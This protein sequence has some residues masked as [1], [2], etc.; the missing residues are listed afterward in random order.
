MTQISIAPCN[1]P[2]AEI[3]N[4][5]LSQ[6]LSEE[7]FSTIRQAF[8]DHGL[9]FFRDQNITPEQ[10]IAFAKRWG[11]INI[12]RF[13]T[14]VDGYPE[15]AEVRKEPNQTTNIGGGW[16][17][18][19]S[20]DAE[21]ATGSILVAR[22]LPPQGGDTMFAD[23]AAA[24][25]ALDDETKDKLDGLEAIHS[26][27]HIFGGEAAYRSESDAG[28]RLQNANAAD[29]LDDVVHPVV[30]THPLSGRKI[31]YVNAA[32]TVG[33]RGWS[34]EDSM[35]LL[36]PLY[37]HAAQNR[38][39]TRFEW[40]PGSIAFWDNRATWHYALNDYQGERRV[41]HRITLEGCALH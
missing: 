36:M 22:E 16:H 40:Q 35:K 8:A 13:F 28:E 38:F 1:G 10:H 15:I 17:T 23:M 14:P 3:G 34:Q 29:A 18:D 30:I 27:K 21:P 4:V 39:V 33:I 6:E 2:G 31:L 12:N 24:H 7:D 41:M 26:S 19:H 20:Y 11:D 37:A 25:D 9:I 5:D 32:F